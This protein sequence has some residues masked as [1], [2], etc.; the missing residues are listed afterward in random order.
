VTDPERLTLIRALA[1]N[2]VENI[3]YG[4]DVQNRPLAHLLK[5][6]AFEMKLELEI[7]FS[8]GGE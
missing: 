8:L 6:I 1:T 7:D 5:E 2:M 3:K 4:A